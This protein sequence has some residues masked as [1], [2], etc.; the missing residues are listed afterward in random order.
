[1]IWRGLEGRSEKEREEK[2]KRIVEKV[3]GKERKIIRM[4]EKRREEGGRVVMVEVEKKRV[5]RE[6][7]ENRGKIKYY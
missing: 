5:A 6:I 1:M 4:R 7:M 2:L 3:L